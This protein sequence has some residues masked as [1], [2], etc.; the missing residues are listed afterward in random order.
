[1]SALGLRVVWLAAGILLDGPER[2]RLLPDVWVYAGPPQLLVYRTPAASGAAGYAPATP[3]G[4]LR[5]LF[6]PEGVPRVEFHW[7]SFIGAAWASDG[8]PAA[9]ARLLSQAGPP[10]WLLL[11][12]AHA[13]LLQPL[14]R[15]RTLPRHPLARLLTPWLPPAPRRATALD[16]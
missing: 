4:R 10:A 1:M 14:R 6:A 2:L 8:E 5:P 15:L 11:C 16:R 12:S 13:T 9:C 3:P 7:S